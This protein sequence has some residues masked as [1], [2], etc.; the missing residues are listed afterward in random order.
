MGTLNIGRCFPH[1][2]R[3]GPDPE[4]LMARSEEPLGKPKGSRGTPLALGP[5]SASRCLHTTLGKS[6]M[7]GNAA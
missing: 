3:A 7:S 1:E 5:G 4:S 2:A 6:D